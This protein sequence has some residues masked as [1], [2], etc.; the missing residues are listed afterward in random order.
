MFGVVP[1]GLW[2]RAC[3]ADEKN[4]IAMGCQSLVLRKDERVI[5][6]DSGL[7]DKW[8]AKGRSIYDIQDGPEQKSPLQHA[9]SNLDI[10]P[11]D[12][13]DVVITHLHFDHAGGL[14][15]KSEAGTLSPTF[16]R[17]RHWVQSEHLDWARSP[18]E[19]DRGSFPSENIEP[20]VE[21]DLFCLTRGEEELFSGL[22]VIPLYGHTKAMQ[23]VLIEGEQ[24]IFFPADLL[25]M[26]AHLH[27]PYIMAYD[28]EPLTTL[29][30]KKRILA[31]AQKE[32]WLLYL[33]HEPEE[34][35]GRVEMFG[36][37]YRLGT[38]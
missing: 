30:E 34:T 32:D 9:L 6:I 3:P 26:K 20:L 13:T 33:E 10:S 31:R 35:L 17:A 14:T 24:P 15:V 29:A 4:R 27:L 36:G 22:G 37:K 21:A 18:T 16:P 8:D 19:K 38:A 28:I 7:G 1:K 25:P 2:E 5:L 11:I 23:A 12:V